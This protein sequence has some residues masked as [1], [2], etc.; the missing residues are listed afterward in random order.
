M[1]WVTCLI[2]AVVSSAGD[3]LNVNHL[4]K[5]KH[6]LDGGCN[7]YQTYNPHI[8]HSDWTCAEVEKEMIRAIKG[9]CVKC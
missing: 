7:I 5:L 2:Y 6:R 9:G 1:I 3:M 4:Q 8:I